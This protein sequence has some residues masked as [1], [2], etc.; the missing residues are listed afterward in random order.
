MCAG[1]PPHDFRVCVMPDVYPT[2]RPDKTRKRRI[3]SNRY[4]SS[5]SSHAI[6][7]FDRFSSLRNGNYAQ[8]FRCQDGTRVQSP[9]SLAAR[10]ILP[11]ANRQ[12]SKIGRTQSGDFAHFRALNARSENIGLELHR[13]CLLLRRHHAQGVQSN[14]RVGL[15]CFQHVA[16]DQQ[17]GS[18]VARIMWL[19]FTHESDRKS[20][21]V[22]TDQYGAPSPV[23][24]GTTTHHW[25]FALWWRNIRNQAS[26]INFISS[27]SH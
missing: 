23:K 5:C 27:R 19:A 2:R 13:N 17:S 26:L 24:A 14:T 25:C 15:H 22:H 8:W 11:E 10:Q 6:A 20:P 16:S 7:R 3:R 21:R 1:L 18:S 12:T 4:Y 9:L